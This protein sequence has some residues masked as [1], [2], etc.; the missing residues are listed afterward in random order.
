MHWATIAAGND[1]LLCI[2]AEEVGLSVMDG[3]GSLGLHG[4]TNRL[5]GRVTDATSLGVISRVTVDCGFA[6]VA[7]LTHRDIRGLGLTPGLEVVAEIEASSIH[8]LR[9]DAADPVALRGEP[10]STG[11][12]MA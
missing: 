3:A 1:A 2:R 6:L 9:Q 4:A 12:R 8:L 10:R 7:Y 11:R 5:A